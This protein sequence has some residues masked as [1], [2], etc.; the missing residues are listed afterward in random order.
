MWIAT[1]SI[2]VATIT[3]SISI[4]TIVNSG[5]PLYISSSTNDHFWR[6]AESVERERG[7]A[8]HIIY[9]YGTTIQS[10]ID[11]EYL[12]TISIEQLGN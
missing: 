6:R 5:I 3:I 1:T 4:R 12:V 11:L 2:I 7:R 8:A 10:T 9:V